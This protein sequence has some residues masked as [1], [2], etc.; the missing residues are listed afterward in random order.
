MQKFF[1]IL[2]AV[3]SVSAGADNLKIVPGFQVC[4]IEYDGGTSGKVRY[5]KTGEKT[6][7]NAHDPVFVESEKVLRTSLL[8]LEEDASYDV[9]VTAGDKKQISSFQTRKFDFPVA[10]T[11]YLTGKDCGRTFKPKSG[12][13]GAYIRYTAAPGFVQAENAQELLFS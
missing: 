12:K 11:V 6:W 7:K 10:E 3:F 4:S 1:I 5:R 8:K 13:P 9:E 2:L